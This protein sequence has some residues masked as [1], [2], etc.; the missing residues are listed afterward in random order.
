MNSKNFIIPKKLQEHK[1]SI[2]S[3]DK[4]FTN[5]E[6]TKKTVHCY[7]HRSYPLY[8]HKHEDFIEIN[9][10]IKGFGV[11]Y[12]NNKRIDVQPGSVFIISPNVSHGYINL[13]ELEIFHI[14]L[15]SF[16]FEKFY[17]GLSAVDGFSSLFPKNSCMGAFEKPYVKSLT[18]NKTNYTSVLNSVNE[19]LSFS[20]N[21][22]ASNLLQTATVCQLIL[23]L[24]V[25]RKNN[26]PKEK[27]NL[28]ISII[29]D[30]IHYM[31]DNISQKITI[32]DIC[33]KFYISKST[34]NRAFTKHTYFSP[35]VYLTKLRIEKAKKLLIETD[36]NITDIALNCGFFDSSHFEKYFKQYEHVTPTAYRQNNSKTTD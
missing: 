3:K 13:G 8:M 32:D 25:F 23:K 27:N 31:E 35:I 29:L 16:F 24:C 17:D 1:F 9:V 14:L 18:L 12:V 5:A 20:K 11:H 36:A 22:V 19:I 15:P 21:S 33:N 4:F 7:F 34:F 2:F 26:V 30:S 6:N 10:V 28:Y